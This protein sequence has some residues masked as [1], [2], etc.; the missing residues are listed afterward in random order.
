MFDVPL[1][2]EGGKH[3][4]GAGLAMG[5][6][7]PV[8]GPLC[9]LGN[10]RSLSDDTLESMQPLHRS[11]SEHLEDSGDEYGAETSSPPPAVPRAA[12]GYSVRA[13]HLCCTICLEPYRDPFVTKCGHTFCYDCLQRQLKE[14][15]HCPKCRGWL[16][17][18]H[19]F[20]NKLI[21][22]VRAMLML[23]I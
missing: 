11:G 9:R 15:N 10:G 19:A 7:S 21:Q 23:I 13:Q 22:E 1:F 12:L 16:V 17:A 2:L 18:E 3:A 8:A 6:G 4:T 20:P 5:E 14:R